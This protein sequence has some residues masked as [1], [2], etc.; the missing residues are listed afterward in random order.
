ML[1][2]IA[3]DFGNVDATFR[4]WGQMCDPQTTAPIAA[5]NAMLGIASGS[6]NVDAPP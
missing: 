1:V 3:S 4:K 6:G 5:A 2:L